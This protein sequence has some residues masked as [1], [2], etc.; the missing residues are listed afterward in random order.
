MLLRNAQCFTLVMALPYLCTAA[1]PMNY[2]RK[3]RGHRMCLTSQDIVNAATCQVGI[4]VDVRPVVRACRL[5]L[6]VP[7]YIER[8]HS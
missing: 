4:A 1:Q 3:P 6:A 2:Q 8:V 7:V 5:R